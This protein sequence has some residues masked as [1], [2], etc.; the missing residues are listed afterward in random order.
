[1][2]P[3]SFQ[4]QSFSNISATPL[5]H[6]ISDNEIDQSGTNG[7]QH[8]TNQQQPTQPIIDNDADVKTKITNNIKIYFFY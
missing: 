4:T 2:N 3:R 7:T 8:S 5:S 1:V 6:S